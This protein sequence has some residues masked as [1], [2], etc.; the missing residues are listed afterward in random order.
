MASTEQFRIGYMIAGHMTTRSLLLLRH[1]RSGHDVYVERDIERHL[2]GEGYGDAYRVAEWMKREGQ[3]PDLVVSSPAVRAYTTAM[4][5]CDSLDYPVD[6]IVIHPGVYE[7]DISRLLGLIAET[8]GSSRRLLLTGHSPGLPDLAGYLCGVA[9]ACF[10]P[11]GLVVIACKGRGWSGM[12]AGSC[13]MTSF[14]RRR[15]AP[16]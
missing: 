5:V 9:P 6:R 14:S 12:K 8:G 13:G 16:A 2:T 3:V 4:I 1:A 15:M 7:G 11:A 10:P